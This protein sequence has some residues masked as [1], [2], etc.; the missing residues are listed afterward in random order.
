M[1][2]TGLTRFPVVDRQRRLVGM[3]GL[4]D[5]LKGRALTL[6]AEKRRERVL[7]TRIAV[8]LGRRR[9]QAAV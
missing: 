9:E 7:G 5:L 2:E 6:E 4:Q 8:L 1:A 3:I